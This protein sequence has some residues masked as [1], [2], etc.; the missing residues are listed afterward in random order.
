MRQWNSVNRSWCSQLTL[1]RV[2]DVTL[3]EAVIAHP[4]GVASEVLARVVVA[5]R[6]HVID[7]ETVMGAILRA[8]A[9]AAASAAPTGT[10]SG[11][12]RVITETVAAGRQAL[13]PRVQ[14]RRGAQLRDTRGVS[15]TRGS[16]RPGLH[17]NHRDHPEHT[18]RCQRRACEPIWSHEALIG[19]RTQNPPKSPP[20]KSP[21]PKSPPLS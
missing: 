11:E 21:L 2:S 20:P 17:T 1:G 14:R 7:V 16:L 18:D 3:A 19:R 6:N 5:K 15:T 4:G 12:I 8:R 10:N 9:S 13:L